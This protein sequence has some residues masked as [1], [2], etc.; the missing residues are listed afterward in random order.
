MCLQAEVCVRYMHI[1]CVGPSSLLFTVHYWLCSLQ[2]VFVTFD[3]HLIYT[4]VYSR[5][6]VEG[7]SCSLIGTTKLPF[8]Q[9]PLM[10]H[11]GEVS[12]Q[13]LTGKVCTY[14]Q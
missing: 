12:C 11:A 2:H 4:Y 5:D 13:T 1:N 6:T 3:E 9:H 10:L 14:V 8:G 7:S